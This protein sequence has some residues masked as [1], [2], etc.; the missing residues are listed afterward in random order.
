MTHTSPQFAFFG[1]PQLAVIVLE[2][3][4]QADLAPSLVVTNPDRPQGR[5]HLLTPPPTK[6]WAAEKGIPVFQPDSLKQLPDK[7][8]LTARSFDLFVVFAYGLI[9]PKNII[10]LPKHG[11]L[12]LHPSLLPQLRGPSPIRSAILHDLRETGVTIMRMDE[13]MDHGPIVAQENAGIPPELWPM[14][15]HELDERLVRQGAQLLA[16]TIPTWIDGA[17]QETPQDHDRATY[18]TLFT[19][20]MAQLHLDPHHLPTGDEAYQTLLKIYAYEGNPGAFF[21][22]RG[23]RVKIV[24]A[25]LSSE[26]S[27]L[28]KT[29]VPEGK[30]PCSFDSFLVSLA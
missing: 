25:A 19:T 11:T 6:K 27:L 18:T 30:K 4:A 12:N 3:L 14:R 17:M 29:V 24:D 15:G 8:P 16:R 23:K 13:Q 5:K 26:G 10:E 22:Y 28:I 21:E 9:M 1:T 2:E 7:H 20:D